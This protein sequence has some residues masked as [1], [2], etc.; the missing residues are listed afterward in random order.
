[1]VVGEPASSDDTHVSR[2][3][4]SLM[5]QTTCTAVVVIRVV[6]FAEARLNRERRE[7]VDAP[8]ERAGVALLLQWFLL[9]SW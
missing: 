2:A 1:M 6:W 4:F 9:R 3:K 5:A 7:T 8:T